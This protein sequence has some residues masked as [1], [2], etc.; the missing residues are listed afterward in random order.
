MPNVTL[1]IDEDLLR[2]GREYAKERGTSLNALIR[3]W[4]ANVTEASDPQIDSMIERLRGSEGKS[5][6]SWTRDDLYSRED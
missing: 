3:T 6:E 4:I 5:E 2:K 1:S